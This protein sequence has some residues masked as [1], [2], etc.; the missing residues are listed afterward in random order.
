MATNV[1]YNFD[2]HTLDITLDEDATK[3]GSED[4]NECIEY[5]YDL[6]SNLVALNVVDADKVTLREFFEALKKAKIVLSAEAE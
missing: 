3:T 6:K 5:E 1:V 2:D 4:Y